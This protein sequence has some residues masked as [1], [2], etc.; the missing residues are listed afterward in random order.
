MDKLFKLTSRRKISS[1]G[2]RKKARDR[3]RMTAKSE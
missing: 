2:E 1:S 3:Q